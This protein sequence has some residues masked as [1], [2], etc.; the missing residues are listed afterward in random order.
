MIMEAGSSTSNFHL[1][2]NRAHVAP[3]MTRWSADQLTCITWA[4]YSSPEGVK[5][6]SVDTLPNAAMATSGGSR[7]GLV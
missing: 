5:R 2:E 6:G 1:L 7:S 3:S 4:E